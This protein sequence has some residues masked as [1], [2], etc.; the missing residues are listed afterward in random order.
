MAKKKQPTT[1]TTAP[2]WPSQKE[3]ENIYG[4]LHPGAV[5]WARRDYHDKQDIA[6]RRERRR[7]AGARRRAKITG[8][9]YNEFGQG[10]GAHRKPPGHG[11]GRR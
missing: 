4:P 9:P 7:L 10:L 11:R 6:M 8:K 3:L 2:P 5:A 1:T